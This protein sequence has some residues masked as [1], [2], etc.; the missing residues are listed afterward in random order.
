MTPNQHEIINQHVA[1]YSNG[2][3]Y[4]G[5]ASAFTLWGLNLSELGVIVS[6]LV[7]VVG[8]GLQLY[9][10]LRRERREREYH[11]VRMETL[12][13]DTQGSRSPRQETRLD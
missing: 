8:L 3:L 5:T 7:A 11:K 1:Q 9:V 4:G 2:A 12:T 13:S 10:M 6:A